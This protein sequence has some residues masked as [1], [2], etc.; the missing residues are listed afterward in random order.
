MYSYRYS[1]THN[2]TTTL[3]HWGH[4]LKEEI[5]ITPEKINWFY[6]LLSDCVG[7]DGIKEEPT[8]REELL[9]YRMHSDR[10]GIGGRGRITIKDFE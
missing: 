7:C 5:K 4:M 3:N 1:Y 2:E 6:R 8:E 9:I 10:F